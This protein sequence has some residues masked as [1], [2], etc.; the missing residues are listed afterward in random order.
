[1]V[2]KSPKAI[3]KT[4]KIDAMMLVSHLAAGRLRFVRIPSL[5]EEFD[6]LATRTGEQLV[7]TRTCLSNQ[8][9]SRLMQFGFLKANE[10]WAMS[11]K[12][13]DALASSEELP[14]ALKEALGRLG[15]AWK[16]VNSEIRSIESA[17]RVKAEVN[18]TKIDIRSLAES[19]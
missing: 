10:D 14:A 17:I 2:E 15:R 16:C 11:E 18:S 4:D 9:K 19:G 8:I 7:E 13:L 3:A 6:R 1:M 12:R 5:E